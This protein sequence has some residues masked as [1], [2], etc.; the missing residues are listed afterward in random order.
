MKTKNI[1]MMAAAM[2]IG[3]ASCSNEDD[4][5]QSNYPMDNVVRINTNVE[6]MKTRAS[7]TTETLDAFGFYIKNEANAKYTYSKIK[8]EKNG[9]NWIPASMMLWQSAKQSVN[10]IAIAPYN[11]YANGDISQ[12]S[13]Y[14]VT[15]EEKQTANSSNSDF[16]A[17][18]N[19]DFVPETGLNSNGAVDVTFTHVFSLLNIKI[20]L[21]N[22]FYGSDGLASN[23][24]KNVKIGGTIISG[25]VDFTT[26]PIGVSVDAT[27]P[28]TLVEPEEG[29]F[30]KS[31]EKEQAAANYSAILIPQTITEGFKVEFDVEITKGSTTEKKTFVWISPNAVKLESGKSHQL[32]LTVGKDLVKGGKIISTPW[33]DGE[34][35]TLETE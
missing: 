17:Y 2:A 18:K 14:P 20:E 26:T 5:A 21:G 11:Q 33:K 1:L 24:I 7:Y 28:T 13:M 9:S 34:G 29:N 12:T 6:G 23:I 3:F 8:V 19:A 22:E 30:E 10:I 31:T 15:V 32:D 25:N 4:L 27:L 16:L 35:G